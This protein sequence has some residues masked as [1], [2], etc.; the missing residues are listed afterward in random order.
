[1]KRKVDNSTELICA[2]RKIMMTVIHN[3]TERSAGYTSTRRNIG[4]AALLWKGEKLNY[5]LL[6]LN[7]TNIYRRY[8]SVLNGK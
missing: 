7:V 4:L 2:I 5:Y 8:F 6:I 1:M 3:L